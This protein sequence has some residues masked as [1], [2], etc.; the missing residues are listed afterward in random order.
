MFK[1]ISKFEIGLSVVIVIIA[2]LIGLLIY[3][4]IREEREC[5]A[6]GG[7]MVQTGGH[8][9]SVVVG[10]VVTMQYIPHFSCNK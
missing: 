5:A 9:Q 2:A 3:A 4:T 7:E 10:K 1:R 8:Y 6:R